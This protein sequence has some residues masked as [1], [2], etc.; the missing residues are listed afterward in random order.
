MSGKITIR[1]LTPEDFRRWH[2]RDPPCRV[3]GKV[4]ERDGE[5]LGIAVVAMMPGAH[6]G[7]MNCKDEL[8]KHPHLLHRAMVRGLREW[9]KKGGTVIRIMCDEEIPRSREWAARLGFEPAGD[10]NGV[11]SK[12]VEA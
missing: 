11:W 4:A 8:R 6:A 2:D 5:L 9:A 1:A 3:W 10:E 7:F 12:R